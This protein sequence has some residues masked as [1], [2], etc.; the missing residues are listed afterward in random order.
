MSLQYVD[1]Y[2]HTNGAVIW[3][4]TV[5]DSYSAPMIVGAGHVFVTDGNELEALSI[6]NHGQVQW[7]DYGQNPGN[8]RFVGANGVIYCADPYDNLVAYDA[9]NGGSLWSVNLPGGVKTGPIVVNGCVWVATTQNGRDQL[10]SY[11]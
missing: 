4:A 1:A 6:A 10:L 7:Y 5:S 8:C 3:S 2:K 11:C 9:A